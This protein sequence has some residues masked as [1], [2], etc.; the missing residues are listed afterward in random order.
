MDADPFTQ[1]VVLLSELLTEGKPVR[2]QL[3]RNGLRGEMVVSPIAETAPAPQLP[4]VDANP[5]GQDRR[6]RWFS[7]IEEEVLRVVS[8]LWQTKAEV[9][10]KCGHSLSTWFGY[11]LAN[12]AD[13][14]ILESGRNGYRFRKES[15]L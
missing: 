9:A 13:R 4:G 5:E 12:L 3:E 8:N 14:D 1:A 7:P 6:G 2:V 10:E 11:V 15:Q